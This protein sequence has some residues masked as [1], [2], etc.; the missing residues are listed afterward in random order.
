MDGYG[1]RDIIRDI[2]LNRLC[3]FDGCLCGSCALRGVSVD[4]SCRKSS[5]SPGKGG[6]MVRVHSA[7]LDSSPE[8]LLAVAEEVVRQLRIEDDW[9]PISVRYCDYAYDHPDPRC[10]YCGKPR[11]SDA[12]YICDG[13]MEKTAF[14]GRSV[15]EK[16]AY[17][18]PVT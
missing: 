8:E 13:C 5:G 14:D 15:A 2:G 1:A 11:E 16:F 6:H 7:H 10:C 9:T 12:Q 4:I 17:V 3:F 18:L